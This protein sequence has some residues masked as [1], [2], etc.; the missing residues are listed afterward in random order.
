MKLSKEAQEK[1]KEIRAIE[2]RYGYIPFR[3][4][5][6]HLADVGINNLDDESVEE[7][8]KQIIAQGEADKA[9]GIRSFFTPELKCAILRCS[10]ELAKFS[11]MTLFAY[12][13][14]HVH[15]DI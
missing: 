15:V 3:L 8:V 11:V 6:T 9:N 5:I 7:G 13:K 1:M 10:G 14:E 2:N 12:I 4:G